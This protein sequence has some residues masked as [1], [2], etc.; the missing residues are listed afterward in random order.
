MTDT[1]TE[2]TTKRHPLTWAALHGQPAAVV[3]GSLVVIARECWAKDDEFPDDR[4]TLRSMVIH[5]YDGD[6]NQLTSNDKPL[7]VYDHNASSEAAAAM[8]GLAVETARLLWRDYVY[9]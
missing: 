8:L 6:G 1:T 3:G 9:D 4:A 7:A 2:T 5:A